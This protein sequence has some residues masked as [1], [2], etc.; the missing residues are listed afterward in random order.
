MIPKIIHQTAK[1]KKISWEE[2][3][4]ISKA[5]KLMPDFEFHLWDDNENEQ[6]VEKYFP[7]YLDRYKLINKGVAKADVARI[8]YMYVFGGIY[9]DTDY[10]FFK[11]P[12]DYFKIN[13]DA[14]VILPLSREY[15]DSYRIGN[16]IFASAPKQ[17]IWLDFLDYIFANREIT[18]LKENR[19]DYWT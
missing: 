18:N 11:S 17:Q 2:N 8:I 6:L 7:Q 4:L 10:K 5:K 3:R 13:N 15:G 9:C 19:I 16:A 14:Q 1:S 12:L